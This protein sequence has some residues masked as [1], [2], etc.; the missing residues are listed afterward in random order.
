MNRDQRLGRWI[1]HLDK[2]IGLAGAQSPVG[3]RLAETKDFF[4]FL[5]TETGALQ[6]RWEARRRAAQDPA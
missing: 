4:E 3:E 1:T 5:R 6:A 2:G